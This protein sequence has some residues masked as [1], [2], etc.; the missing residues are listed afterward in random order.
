MLIMQF[1]IIPLVGESKFVELTK[2]S[3]FAKT[4]GQ[5]VTAKEVPKLQ[6][7]NQFLYLLVAQGFFAGLAIGK[8]TEGSIRSGIKHS[9]ILAVLAFLISTGANSLFG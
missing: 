6:I 5:T 1:K 7:A 4:Y 9:F 2:V 3:D 8:L